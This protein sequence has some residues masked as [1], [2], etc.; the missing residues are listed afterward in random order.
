MIHLICPRV[1]PR[2]VNDL[3]LFPSTRNVLCINCLHCFVYSDCIYKWT[4]NELELEL[5]VH[6]LLSGVTFGIRG[7][8]FDII[9][10]FT[11]CHGLGLSPYTAHMLQTSEKP[12]TLLPMG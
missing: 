11:N 9:Y 3:L 12:Y 8:G 1:Q 4:I 2:K 7:K 6:E 10:L 5:E